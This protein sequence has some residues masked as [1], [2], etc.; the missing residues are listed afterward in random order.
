MK[1][2]Y[3]LLTF[4]FSLMTLL[5]G[6]GTSSPT[7]PVPQDPPPADV[8]L[9][10][11]QSESE[12]EPSQEE[13]SPL[14]AYQELLQAAPALE[15]E[16]EELLDASFGYDENQEMFEDHIERFALL[17]LD[18]DGTPELITESTVNFR[19]NIVSVY[20]LVDGNAVLLLTSPV[21]AAHGT[22]D[23]QSTANGAYLTFICEDSHIHSRWSGTDPSGAEAEEDHAYLLEGITLTETDC[24]VGENEAATC[25]YDIAQVNSPENVEAMTA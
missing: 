7:E 9:E 10:G 11:E 4:L 6:C 14:L 19:W 17:D 24:T 16:P 15:G 13:S 1:A 3:I 20:T 18:K 8:S 23:Q 12:A 21:E 22:F 25:F 2:K 5:G